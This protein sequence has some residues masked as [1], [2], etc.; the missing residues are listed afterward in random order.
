MSASG[1]KKERMRQQERQTDEPGARRHRGEIRGN[2]WRGEGGR[3]RVV[4][5]E[6]EGGSAGA[7]CR[8][9]SCSGGVAFT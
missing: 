2:R 3:G 5:L 9:A 6:R 8:E 7:A 4:Y 1:I